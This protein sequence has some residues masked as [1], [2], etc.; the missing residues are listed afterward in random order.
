VSGTQVTF[1]DQ[2]RVADDPEGDE[3]NSSKEARRL[4]FYLF[5]NIRPSYDRR[6]W[7]PPLPPSLGLNNPC[8]HQELRASLPCVLTLGPIG[9]MPFFSVCSCKPP[10]LKPIG[11]TW[12]YLACGIGHGNLIWQPMIGYSFQ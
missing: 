9:A 4:A 5:W 2:I 6:V 11:Y 12:S 7:P 1:T 10:S 8:I 3:V